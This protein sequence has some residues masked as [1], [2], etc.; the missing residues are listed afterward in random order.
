[1]SSAYTTEDQQAGDDVAALAANRAGKYLTFF[2]AGE[3]YAIDILRVHEIIG[4]L[5]ITRVPRAPDF[6]LGVINLR[7][8]V[9]PTIDLRL[10]FGMEPKE[11]SR[12]TCI[13]VVQAAGTQI[14]V[15]VDRVSDVLDVAADEVEDVPGFGADVDT[16]CLLG[17]AKTDG[18][19]R[20]LLD[21]ERV[22]RSQDVL[23][24]HPGRLAET[25]VE[26]S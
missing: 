5:P 10:K 26:E 8:R 23:S 21:I 9:I 16:S 22:L 4:M 12:E 20:L 15:V 18:R 7:G 3:E 25:G 17:V 13:V 11:A 1:M 6:I 2:L 24:L 19:V 14:G